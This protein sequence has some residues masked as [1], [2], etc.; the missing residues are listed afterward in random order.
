MRLTVEQLEVARSL[1]FVPTLEQ[2]FVHKA[3]ER[4]AGA[5]ILD[6]E[7]SIAPSQKDAACAA[8]ADAMAV[9]KGNAVRHVLVRVN[10]GVERDTA[11]AAATQA[12]AVLVP[13]VRTL[14]D[15]EQVSGAL[16][17]AQGFGASHDDA[18]ALVLLVETPQAVL[19]ASSIAAH[20]RVVGLVLGSEDL[21]LS[22]GVPPTPAALG[23]A[24]QQ[25]VY[26]CRAA[27]KVPLGVPD[28]LA[29]F[30]NDGGF[31]EAAA[32]GRDMGMAGAVCI[33]PNQV[34]QVNAAFSPSAEELEEASRILEIFQAA[35][36][37]GKG[38]VSLDGKMLDLPIVHR[39]R[40]LLVRAGR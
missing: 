29:S 6:L 4:G 25:I 27:G 33:H 36:A 17:H 1:L 13:K 14:A 2:R 24:A 39:A 30:V 3:H 26:A 21:A 28:S 35:G 22:L 19:N 34:A 20:P 8:L 23:Y 16:E 10:A 31:R 40:D 37:E 18:I 15:V 5:I 32:R 7:D 38:A 9:L 12:D 11:A